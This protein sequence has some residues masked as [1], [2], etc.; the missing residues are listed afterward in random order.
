M[1]RE[2]IRI[3]F[4]R[5]LRQTAGMVESLLKLA[6]L[7]WPVPNFSTLCR[8][9]KTLAVQVTSRRADGPLNQLVDSPGIKLLGDGAWQASPGSKP[10]GT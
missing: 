5:P 10:S 1:S 8:G 2:G 3:R 4:K 6:G 7:D 9:P